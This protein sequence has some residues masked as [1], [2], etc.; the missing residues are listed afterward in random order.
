MSSRITTTLI[1]G[2]N[3]VLIPAARGTLVKPNELE[4]AV[5]RPSTLA[6]YQPNSPATLRAASLAYGLIMGHPF[7]DGNKR[8]AFWAANEYLKEQLGKG[9]TDIPL[10]S[11]NMT[12]TAMQSIGEAHSR[13]AQGLLGYEQLAEVYE[14]VLNRR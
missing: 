9:L 14:H 10:T 8:T 3:R 4:S 1:S 7:L 12:D 13:V 2:I 6:Y 11:V 5:S